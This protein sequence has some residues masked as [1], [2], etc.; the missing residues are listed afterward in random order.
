MAADGESFDGSARLE[1]LA[2]IMPD[3]KVKVVD[4]A[5]DTIVVNRRIDIPTVDD[6]RA[7]RLGYAANAVQV[8]DWNPD[9]ERLAALAADDAMIADLA[10]QENASLKALTEYSGG[11]E[12][13]VGREGRLYNAGEGHTI[14]PFKLAY[15]I[16][17]AYRA[18]ESQA[19]ELYA[20]QGQLT[21]WYRRRFKS[22]VTSDAHMARGDVD[23]AM[24]AAKFIKSELEHYSDFSFID[25]DDEGSP[26]REIKLF[27]ECLVKLKRRKSFILCLTDGN[28]LNLKLLGKFYPTL[29]LLDGKPRQALTADYENFEDYVTGFVERACA[30]NG[31]EPTQ[32]SSYRG[33]EGNVVFQTWMIQ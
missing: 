29:Y 12:K 19:I 9:G 17:A 16:E 1:M 11:S 13:A 23:Y 18:R 28:G 14:E 5:G 30:A 2:D 4:T 6:P 20:G 26:A 7:R 31:F 15:R 21:A 10:R 32:I 25:F 27:L 3:V 24:S 8:M 33:R 22:I